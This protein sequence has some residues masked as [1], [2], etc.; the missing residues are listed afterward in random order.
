M[1]AHPDFVVN[2]C[3]EVLAE[4]ISILTVLHCQPMEREIEVVAAVIYHEGAFLCVQRGKHPFAYLSGKFEF[5]GGKTEPGEQ[6]AAALIREIREELD[7]NIHPLRHLITVNHSY[8]DFSIRLQAW[9]CRCDSIEYNLK[10]HLSACWLP[11][12]QLKQLD[13][14]AADLPVVDFLFR[15]PELSG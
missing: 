1:I 14:A 3:K 2:P 12:E 10:E 7:M 5:P 8:P 6:A 11:P 15:N 13:W 4:R 9:L